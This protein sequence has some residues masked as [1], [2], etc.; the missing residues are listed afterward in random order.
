MALGMRPGQPSEHHSSRGR[1]QE[2]PGGRLTAGGVGEGQ[3]GGPDNSSPVGRVHGIAVECLEQLTA[4]RMQA[5]E[6]AGLLREAGIPLPLA[7]SACE[8]AVLAREEGAVERLALELAAAAAMA[9]DPTGESTDGR[10]GYGPGAPNEGDW[11]R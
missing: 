10:L 9:G 3:A 7:Q 2:Q 6:A 1:E 11:F 5:E 4:G 8:R